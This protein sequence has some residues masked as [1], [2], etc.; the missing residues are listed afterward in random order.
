MGAA[1]ELIGNAAVPAPPPSVI[2]PYTVYTPS[3]GKGTNCTVVGVIPVVEAGTTM[4]VPP[5]VTVNEATGPTDDST[6]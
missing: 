2:V 6:E 5:P 3:A 1:I 4:G